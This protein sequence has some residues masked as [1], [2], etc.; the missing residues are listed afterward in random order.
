MNEILFISDLH[1]DP[2]RPAI[3]KLFHQFLE[4]RATK[5]ETL[6]ILGDLFEAWIGD[7]DDEPAYREIKQA[8]HRL[9]STGVAL[10]F[11]RG[12]RDFLIGE[13]FAAETGCRLLNDPYKIDLYGIPTLLMHGDLLC[14]QDTAY[15]AFREQVR[16]P[17][18]QQGFLTKPAEERRL[19]AQ[20]ARR[21]SKQQTQ[22]KA[23]YIMDVVPQ[24]VND[25][26][27]FHQ[28]ERLIHG[29]THRPGIHKFALQGKT[30]QRIVLGDWYQQ[31]SI[32]S[33]SERRWNLENA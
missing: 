30:V 31:S 25:M 32:L 24:T 3:I 4:Q 17:V 20:A 22:D 6:Y 15:Q 11:M 33:V 16:N 18:W 1:L 19:M 27:L 26:L 8:L 9:N 13:R 10:Y 29:H 28:V 14:T 23:E 21:Q 5:A 7:D 2:Q 12:N